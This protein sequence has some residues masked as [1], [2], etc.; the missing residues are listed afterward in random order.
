M[1]I[2]WIYNLPLKPEVGGTERITSLIARGLTLRGHH[3]MGILVF[4]EHTGRMSYCSNPILDLYMFL[5]EHKVDIVINQ[6]A[7][8]NWLLDSFLDNGGRKWKQEGGRI[9][10]CLHFDPKNPSLL[11]L[12]RRKKKKNLFD[13]ICIL[14]AAV[15]YKLYKIKQEIK[16]GS[17]Y[18][19][20]YDES[21]WFVTLSHT[22]FAYLQK[23]MKRNEYS[24]LVAIN[25]PLTFDDISNTDV[26][27]EKKKIVLV[28][29]RMSEYHKR[30]S[31][32]LK[33]WKM[34][35]KSDVA[36]NWTLI[37]LGDGPDLE[38]YKKYVIANN[39]QNIKFEGQQSP[40]LYYRAASIM[41]LT[42]SAE[43]WGLTITESL[44]RGV[45]P[46]VM[47]SSP[48]FEDMIQDG[49]N[50]FLTPNNNIRMFKNKIMKLMTDAVVLRNM[51]FAALASA[52]AFSLEKTMAKWD[53]IIS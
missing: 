35:Q 22:H 12:L 50:G 37:L 33:A 17:I 1:T 21:D 32:I 16:E 24:R 46:I 8:S 4:D 31:I 27:Y 19:H 41:L 7:Y 48:V 45:V 44:Q 40:E 18:N 29:A 49:I 30:I 28:C 51:Q 6:I 23:V 43:G 39:I 53:K 34:L 15:L 14:K 2:L 5:N 36:H 3:C 25:N 10:S 47:N 42:S 38:R 52:E 9:I 26:I 13:R 11:F 20:I